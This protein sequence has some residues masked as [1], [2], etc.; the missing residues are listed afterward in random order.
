[1]STKPELRGIDTMSFGMHVNDKALQLTAATQVT[2]KKGVA[3]WRFRVLVHDRLLVLQL[4]PVRGPHH[5][6]HDG[7]EVVGWRNVHHRHNPHGSGVTNVTHARRNDSLEVQI[8]GGSMPNDTCDGAPPTCNQFLKLR[9]QYAVTRGRSPL[10][11]SHPM[12]WNNIVRRNKVEQN[13]IG[14]NRRKLSPIRVLR[15]RKLGGGTKT[16]VPAPMA[17]ELP[18]GFHPPP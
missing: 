15:L 11:S 10:A 18:Q 12:P 5:L 8:H 7:L 14:P 9:V 13:A 16:N 4:S 1:M 17:R 2:S 3:A 6:R